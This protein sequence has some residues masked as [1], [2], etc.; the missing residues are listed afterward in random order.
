MKRE[1]K[2][3][4][5]Y[6]LI[7]SRNWNLKSSNHQLNAAGH[8]KR[9]RS[10]DEEEESLPTT[11]PEMNADQ[12]QEELGLDPPTDHHSKRHSSENDYEGKQSLTFFDTFV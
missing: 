9:N 7:V 11:N 6:H 10:N 5:K 8:Y 3:S 12:Q 1:K 2:T 4:L